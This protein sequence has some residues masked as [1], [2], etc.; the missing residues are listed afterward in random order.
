MKNVHQLLYRIGK[1]EQLSPAARDHTEYVR[2]VARW[3]KQARHIL[4]DL[5]TLKTETPEDITDIHTLLL[6]IKELSTAI[7]S[8]T[9]GLTATHI[10]SNSKLGE[11]KSGLTLLD[12]LDIVT[13]YFADLYPF[14]ETLYYCLY[15]RD[16]L[17]TPN[18]L[19]KTLLDNYQPLQRERILKQLAKDLQV[20]ID[21]ALPSDPQF[22][23]TTDLFVSSTSLLQQ[24]VTMFARY[25]NLAIYYNIDL[26]LVPDVLVEDIPQSVSVIISPEY[27]PIVLSTLQ[28][29]SEQYADGEEVSDPTSLILTLLTVNTKI[30][31]SGLFVDRIT[32]H[33]MTDNDYY[34]LEHKKGVGLITFRN[35][36]GSAYSILLRDITVYTELL[37]TKLTKQPVLTASGVVN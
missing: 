23:E 8:L 34:S 12:Q 24:Y 3:Y 4:K 36:D 22:A 7:E 25:Q 11:K 26:G 20:T 19:G 17:N 37:P 30:I 9:R 10:P 13:D 27:D 33:S 28:D 32:R 5:E 1:L 21:S 31:I 2:E 14:L 35:D 6:D 18:P 29:V 16:V 15:W